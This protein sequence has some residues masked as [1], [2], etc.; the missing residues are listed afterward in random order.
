MRWALGLVALLVAMVI[1]LTLSSRQAER[2]LRDASRPIGSLK[3]NVAPVAFDS[4]AAL[5]LADRLEALADEADLPAGE[6]H[7][8]ALTAASWAAGSE[9]GSG[10]YRAAVKLRGAADNLI[11]SSGSGGD[12]PRRGAA[13]RLVREAREAMTSQLAQPGG[14]TG[15]IRDQLENLQYSHREQLEEAERADQ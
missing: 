9:P 4:A 15:A 10:P 2:T 14:P 1:A 7:E 5:A 3:E 6:L 11:A 8:A 12:D 13:R